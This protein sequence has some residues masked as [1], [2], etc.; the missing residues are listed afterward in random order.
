MPKNDNSQP[1]PNGFAKIN[2]NLINIHEI[3]RKWTA[4]GEAVP[5]SV[6]NLHIDLEVNS[7]RFD[8]HPVYYWRT[9]WKW[10]HERVKK[11]LTHR[12]FIDNLSTI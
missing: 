8:S 4:N 12:Q 7:G 10:S 5:E 1:Y 3:L 11:L 2:H 6:A 9:C